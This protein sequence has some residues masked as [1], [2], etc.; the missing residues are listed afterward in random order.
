[1]SDMGYV[2]MYMVC[3][4]LWCSGIQTE[5][6]LSIKESDYTALIPKMHDMFPFMALLKEV[7]FIFDI[8]LPNTE[9]FFKILE[10][11][12]ICIDVA[13]S[14]MFTPQTKNI[15]INYHHFRIFVHKKLILV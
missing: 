2:I 10:D 4:V 12:Q 1:M 9:I 3:L 15:A 14:N 7:S 11:S 13:Q 8:H 6:I 5:I